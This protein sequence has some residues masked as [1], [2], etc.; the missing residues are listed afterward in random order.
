MIISPHILFNDCYGK[1]AIAAINVFTLEQVLGVFRAAHKSRAP[2]II[3]TTPVAR[4][5]ATP[6][7][8][9]AMVAAAARVYPEVV[10]ALHLDH[11]NEQHIGEAVGSGRY[12]PVMIDA[13]HDPLEQNISRT[14]EVVSLAH[15]KNVF[16]EAE[17]GVLSGIEDHLQVSASES[18]Y[19]GPDEAAYFVKSAGCDS[20]AVAV[21]TSHG[22]Y[23]FSGD[24]GIQ[25]GILRAIQQRLPGFPLVLHGG[26][27]VNADELARINAA[28][29]QMQ[30]GARGVSDEELSQAT[31]Y[32]IC[33]VNVATDL[34]VLWARVHREFFADHPDR[35][36]PVEPGRVYVE[37]LEKLCTEK[38]EKLGAAGKADAFLR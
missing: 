28:G 6:Q 4:D 17:L 15:G 32:G 36:D 33:K 19:T 2:V 31:A 5:Y 23:K 9:T 30:R 7:V 22:A 27:S 38:F 3:Q 29:G 10:F 8:L 25:F 21:G 16:V 24:E 35:F 26:S 37:A 13:S 18:K 11:G 1:Y 12:S 14:R 20:L 34:R